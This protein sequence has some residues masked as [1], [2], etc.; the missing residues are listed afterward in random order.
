M[1]GER[2]ILDNFRSLRPGL[3]P[4]RFM[5]RLIILEAQEHVEI[6]AQTIEINQNAPLLNPSP[7]LSIP[8]NQECVYFFPTMPLMMS[9]AKLG[10]RDEESGSNSAFNY[11]C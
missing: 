9:I 4:D 11:K 2:P 10:M 7:I 6:L 3:L 5:K 8:G 1:D